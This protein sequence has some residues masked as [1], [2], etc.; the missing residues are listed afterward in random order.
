MKKFLIILFVLVLLAI[1]IVAAVFLFTKGLTQS[2]DQFFKPIREG[3]FAAAYALLSEDFRA[4]TSREEFDLFLQKSALANYQDASWTSRSLSGKTGELEGTVTTKEGGTIPLKIKFVKEQGQWKILSI[5]KP[6]AGL[7]PEESKGK[8]IPAETELATMADTALHDFALAVNKGDFTDFHAT[9]SD[10]WKSQITPEKL[11][12]IFQEFVKQKVD[13]TVLSQYQLVFSQPPKISEE[14]L[15]E[16]EGYYP[17]QPSTTYF[18]LSYV[19]E[20]PDWKLAGIR[21]TLK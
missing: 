19:Y 8:T 18:A 2:A 15:L 12:E 13:L 4:A 7:V 10:L 5:E 17:T 11:L 16:L 14:G 21:V 3:D 20:H 1:V 9:L 6:A